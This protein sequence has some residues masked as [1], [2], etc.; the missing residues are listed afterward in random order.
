MPDP[1]SGRLA[2]Q[3][4]SQECRWTCTDTVLSLD[5]DVG[6]EKLGPGEGDSALEVPGRLTSNLSVL[7]AVHQCNP[8]APGTHSEPDARERSGRCSM[9]GSGLERWVSSSAIKKVEK[10]SMLTQFIVPLT[11]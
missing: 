7:S 1:E 8:A 3:A 10:G 2:M 9:S 11:F 4:A 6:V 5:S